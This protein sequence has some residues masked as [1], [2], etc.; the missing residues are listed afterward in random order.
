[1]STPVIRRND[2]ISAGG[3]QPKRE[4]HPP[5]SKDLPY[6]DIPKKLRKVR[7]VKDNPNAEQLRFCSKLLNNLHYKTHWTITSSFYKPAGTSSWPLEQA[8]YF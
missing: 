3:S 7:A 2:S 8:N 6:A 1:M 5:P 4:I